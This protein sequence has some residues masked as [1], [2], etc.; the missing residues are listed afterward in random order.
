L[1][2]SARST[3]DAPN[4]D[5]RLPVNPRGPQGGLRPEV[6]AS[7]RAHGNGNRPCW[8][9]RIETAHLGPAGACLPL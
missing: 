1:K 6:G 2:E 7:G 5:M 8:Y 9:P 4:V 3:A